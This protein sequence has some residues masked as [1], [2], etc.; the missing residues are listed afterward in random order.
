MIYIRLKNRGLLLTTVLIVG[1]FVSIP[2]CMGD[3]TVT[4]DVLF[5]LV[6]P[7]SLN[8]YY[9]SFTENVTFYNASYVSN[10]LLAFTDF[11]M[12]GA[13]TDSWAVSLSGSNI[14]ISRFDLNNQIVY[15]ADSAGTQSFW[16]YK[17]PT[18]V[19]F[20]GIAVSSYSYSAGV[21]NVTGAAAGSSVTISFYE[22]TT[23]TSM[24]D[25]FFLGYTHSVLNVTGYATSEQAGWTYASA[26]QTFTGTGTVEYGFK[27]WVLHSD[28]SPPDYI[29]GSALSP[30]AV[31]TRGSAGVGMQNA[32][33]YVSGHPLVIGLNAL[34]ISMYVRFDGGDWLVLA[35][36]VSDLLVQ[37]AIVAGN[38]TFNMYTSVTTDG[39]DTVA[40]AYWGDQTR[41]SGIGGV[42]FTDPLPQEIALYKGL[43]GDWIGMFLYPFVYIIGDI[44]YGIILLFVGGN[45]Y[46]RHRR[47]EIILIMLVLWGSTSGIGLLIPFEGFRIIYI[48]ALIGIAALI[49]KVYR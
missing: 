20:N 37:K 5:D 10:S 18:Q 31:L 8:H 25:Y 43:T 4:S 3:I 12:L 48:I 40:S 47:F 27:A 44:F 36:F 2:F 19:T 13:N 38:W 6:D 9:L 46:L 16:T 21:L 39:A 11:T 1:L 14:T 7:S 23:G 33:V 41:L 32:S 28:S 35:T 34:K 15:T 22:D 26:Q 17:I 30:D 49:Y 42:V 29:V 45:L 24:A